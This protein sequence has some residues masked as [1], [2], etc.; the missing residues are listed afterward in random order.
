M[1]MYVFLSGGRYELPYLYAKNVKEMNAKTGIPV[2]KIYRGFAWA[3][4]TM[5]SKNAKKKIGRIRM[6]DAF[7]MPEDES[8]IDLTDEEWEHYLRWKENYEEGL[9]KLCKL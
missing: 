2:K 1:L 5:H 7:D 8:T 9:R 4:E 3:R 6:F